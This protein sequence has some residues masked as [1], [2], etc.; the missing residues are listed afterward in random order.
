MKTTRGVGE[1]QN[2]NFLEFVLRICFQILKNN[3]VDVEIDSIKSHCSTF[4]N[5]LAKLE[6]LI[7]SS[8]RK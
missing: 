3:L 7:F 8:Y 5:S 6:C 2:L 4:Q 1:E